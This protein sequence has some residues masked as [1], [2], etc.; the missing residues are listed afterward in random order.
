MRA[1]TER[2]VCPDGGVCHH[3]CTDG[4][5]RNCSRVSSCAPLSGVYVNDHWP[6]F[7]PAAPAPE[8]T[9]ENA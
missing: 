3:E 8:S 1:L 9:E 5:L 2:N 6:E 4:S 7:E